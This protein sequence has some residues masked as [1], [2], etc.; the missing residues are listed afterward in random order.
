MDSYIDSRL[1][2]I[3]SVSADVLN[4]NSLL[5]DVIFAF[6]GMLKDDEDI[7]YTQISIMNAQIPISYY[8]ISEYVNRFVYS[9]DGGSEQIRYF[10]LGNYNANSFITEIVAKTGISVSLNKQNGRF[11]FT[12]T[13]PFII[14]PTSTCY[15]IIGLKRDMTYE[16]IG[17]SMNADF[18][19]NFAGIT[20]IKVSSSMLSTYSMDSVSSG[21]NNTLQTI[22]VNSGSFGILLYENSH[23]Y[24][25][26]L[27]NKVIDYFDIR[28]YDDNENLIDFN[29][30]HWN[31]TLQLDIVRKTKAES[32]GKIT[33]DATLTQND[34]QN[35]EQA[36]LQNEIKGTGD[37]DLDLLLYQNGQYI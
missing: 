2:N 12:H 19:C 26:L 1:I 31:M 3:S 23:G 25:A 16:S 28:I 6:P 29:G 14:Y 4:N 17:N 15:E 10:E 33:T 24:K 30:V 35:Q 36:P 20:R 37:N 11:T 34:S 32:I 21:F 8:T 22:S 13:S 7:L 9:I 27:R 18:P 5:S